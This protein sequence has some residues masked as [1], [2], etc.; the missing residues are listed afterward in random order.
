MAKIPCMICSGD[1]KVEEGRDCPTCT[2]SGEVEAEFGM[3]EGH[4]MAVFNMTVAI[5]DKVTDILDKCEDI[6]EKVNE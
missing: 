5:L 3:T 6:L 1:G 2:G 4:Q